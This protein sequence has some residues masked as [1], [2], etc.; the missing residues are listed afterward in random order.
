MLS[1][2]ARLPCS[3]TPPPPSRAPQPLAE[4]T[5]NELDKAR[6]WPPGSNANAGD[7]GSNWLGDPVYD[8]SDD[9]EAEDYYEE[10]LAKIAANKARRAAAKRPTAA[11]P[12][13]DQNYPAARPHARTRAHMTSYDGPPPPASGTVHLM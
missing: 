3:F 4:A 11:R 8:S 1:S 10:D 7:R 2:P 6:A 5:A 12:A 13:A 9:S